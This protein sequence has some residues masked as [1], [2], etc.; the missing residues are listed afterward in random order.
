MTCTHS[1]NSFILPLKKNRWQE[2]VYEKI[3]HLALDSEAKKVKHIEDLIEKGIAAHSHDA[4]DRSEREKA[5]REA[6]VKD[7]EVNRKIQVDR[8]IKSKI[9]AKKEVLSWKK[10]IEEQ[11]ANHVAQVKAK[12]EKK[13]AQDQHF[14]ALQLQQIVR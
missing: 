14:K 4:E 10:E 11:D 7:T 8:H 2:E 6:L 12:K 3:A 9:D 13:M 1:Q 5:Y